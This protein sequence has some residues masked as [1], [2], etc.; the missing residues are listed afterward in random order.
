MLYF[1]QSFSIFIHYKIKAHQ[2]LVKK[3]LLPD[4]CTFLCCVYL[5]VFFVAYTKLWQYKSWYCVTVKREVTITSGISTYRLLYS[6][7]RSEP[8]EENQ[9]WIEN[10]YIDVNNT[11]RFLIHLKTCPYTG[12][13]ALGTGTQPTSI[14]GVLDT[15]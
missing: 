13:W 5:F 14:S 9:K 11:D 10:W 1:H 15:Y 12:Q 3:K 8:A 7:S 4:I 2:E 6:S